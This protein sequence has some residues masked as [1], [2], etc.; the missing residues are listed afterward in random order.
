MTCGKCTKRHSRRDRSV[1]GC[2]GRDSRQLLP[3]TV[4]RPSAVSPAPPAV[5]RAINNPWLPPLT[6]PAS[7]ARLRAVGEVK[8]MAPPRAR[9]VG[10]CV[11][12]WHHGI[13]RTKGSTTRLW[14]LPSGS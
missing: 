5:R 12:A 2:C 10:E 9:A 6:Y 4:T 1:P 13:P 14:L 11:G 7:G 8:S 3:S